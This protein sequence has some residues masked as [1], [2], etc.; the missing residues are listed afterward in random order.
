M[1]K[2]G[3]QPIRRHQ[4]IL[5]TIGCMSEHGF[6][7]TTIA[8]IGKAANMTPSIIHHYFGGKDDLLEASMR[9][10]LEQLRQQLVERLHATDDP[11][12]RVEIIVAA[13]FSDE[14][15]SRDVVGAWMAFWGQAQ[16]HPAL[17]RLY[18][19]YARRLHANLRHALRQLLPE[20]DVERAAFGLASLIDG[21][22]LNCALSGEANG[23]LAREVASNYVA[24]LLGTAQSAPTQEA[25]LSNA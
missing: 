14:Q 6:E 17:H 18:R 16:H 13:N 4:L 11:R 21:L 23:Q 2:L 7:R 15:F 3:M 22:W 20:R 10:L 12:A 5:A 24:T 19:V 8:R 9:Y 1:P 25:E